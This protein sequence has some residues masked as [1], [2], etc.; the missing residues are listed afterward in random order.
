[1]SLQTSEINPPGFGGVWK[2]NTDIAAFN[3]PG[4]GSFSLDYNIF[5]GCTYLD[6]KF[7]DSNSKDLEGLLSVLTEGFFIMSSIAEPSRF[8]IFFMTIDTLAVTHATFAITY[9]DGNDAILFRANERV[10]IT[11]IGGGGV[12][13][14]GTSGASGASGVG[15][16]GYSG[17]SGRSGT[18]GVPGFAGVTGVTGANGT[19]GFSGYSG[20]ES[21][22]I[23]QT[24]FVSK[25][26]NDGTAV[27][28]NQSK[29]YL[30]ITAAAT[31]AAAGDTIVVS[32]GT[33]NE[34]AF[35][36]T[37]LNFYFH[38]G[39]IISHTGILFNITT[40]TTCVDGYGEF[41]SN[42]A[43]GGQ[44]PV[45][46]SNATLKMRCKS[47]SGVEQAVA[48][49]Q[50]GD[51]MIEADTISAGQRTVHALD[52]TGTMIVKCKTITCTAASGAVNGPSV[53]T[54]NNGSGSFALDADRVVISGSVTAHY[55]EN[56]TGSAKLTVRNWISTY[57][58][59][60]VNSLICISGASNVYVE[61]DISVAGITNA[62]KL[63]GAGTTFVDIK[64]GIKVYQGMVVH[65]GTSDCTVH[66]AGDI[67][68]QT[69]EAA[70]GSDVAAVAG[71]T[72]TSNNTFRMT[73]TLSQFGTGAHGIF[74]E[75]TASAPVNK[76]EILNAKIYVDDVSGSSV[77]GTTPPGTPATNPITVG[78]LLSN[79]A[80]D[81][82]I[83]VEGGTPI[84]GSY[85]TGEM[86]PTTV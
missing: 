24:I 9:L 48:T 57:S 60:T 22:I 83:T 47:L 84:V 3:D 59:G 82:N 51:V 42:T 75:L 72:G 34:S 4:A 37:N 28:Y 44:V 61:G 15:E 67:S 43:G 6:I 55:F 31:A 23:P 33:Y 56:N 27:A 52:W 7:V 62:V 25:G 46:V 38:P 17:Y 26:G 76:I 49:Y 53:T 13:T 74:S 73:G 86:L 64:G 12:G 21:I 2:F 66:Y 14:N 30:T 20:S 50:S 81:G 68:A 32:P 29:P 18:S 54:V 11:W 69:Q 39:A 41:I 8:A 80:V 5:S 10:L 40:G 36:V 65:F 58:G 45:F 16:S 79:V 1:M 71:S 78:K 70:N 35:A 77:A 63:I 85:V 19:S